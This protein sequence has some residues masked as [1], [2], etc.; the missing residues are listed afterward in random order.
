ML[1]N[2]YERIILAKYEIILKE[3]ES[4]YKKEWIS[5]KGYGIIKEDIDYLINN[6]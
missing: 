1:D 5:D 4:C 6:L 3:L 2:V